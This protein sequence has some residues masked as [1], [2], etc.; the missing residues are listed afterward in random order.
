MSRSQQR[1]I[2]KVLRRELLGVNHFNI[3]ISV[4]QLMDDIEKHGLM[5]VCRNI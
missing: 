4:Q 2:Q 1:L 3:N 5:T